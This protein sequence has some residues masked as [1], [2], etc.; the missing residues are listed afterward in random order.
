VLQ[1]PLTPAEM[2]AFDAVVMR[3]ATKASRKR[4]VI[5]RRALNRI[6]PAISR[7]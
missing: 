7:D 6:C 2:A 4:P 1:V 5:A 3:G